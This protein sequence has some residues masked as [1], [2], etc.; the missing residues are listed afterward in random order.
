M[1][2]T[3]NI[4]QQGSLRT[5]QQ[6]LRQIQAAQ[7]QIASGLRMQK[8]SDDPIG[9]A[10]SMR[11]RGSLRA[12]EQ[13]RRGIQSA[14]ARATAE[15][16]ALDQLTAILIRARELATMYA[17]DNADAADRRTGQIEIESLLRQVVAVANVRF[18]DG[19]LFG[20]T[21]S[22]AQPYAVDESGPHLGFTSIDPA[23]QHEIQI[24]ERQR[25]V[26][27]RNGKEVFEDTGALA[28][29]RDLAQAL[30]SNDIPAVRQRLG[31]LEHSF[32]DVQA[33][34]GE[35]GAR[36]NLLQVTGANLD[37]LELNLR[38]LKSSAEEVDIERAITELVGRQT[39]FQ[40]AL[41][42]TSQVMSLNLANY[43]R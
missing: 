4:I 30:G 7:L 16:T 17:G 41:L 10:D 40:A 35:V 9:A 26:T 31:D 20:G 1:R 24:S 19:Y 25:V 33:L 36:T 15:E 37:A 42:A 12:L 13:Y 6:N 38:T 23:G 5:I 11:A 3:N 8:A 43:L 29:L 28:A 14:E 18:D 39:T 32:K 22:T 21:G 34:L 2:I 27:N